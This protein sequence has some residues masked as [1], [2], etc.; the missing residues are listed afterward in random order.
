MIDDTPKL[1]LAERMTALRAKQ[2]LEANPAAR[3]EASNKSP[4]SLFIVLFTKS[5]TAY[6]KDYM[7][8]AKYLLRWLTPIDWEEQDGCPLDLEIEKYPLI[9]DTSF[10]PTNL[11]GSYSLTELSRI[12][13][14]AYC[15][16]DKDFAK[17]MLESNKI[18]R[19]MFLTAIDLTLRG[20]I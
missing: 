4:M 13:A 17:Y 1:S 5:Y 9:E 2:A 8:G 12:I 6:Y 15:P 20:V 14:N 16:M 7:L 19:A 10:K 18:Y 11:L 3:S